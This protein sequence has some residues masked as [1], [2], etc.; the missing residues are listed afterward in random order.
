MPNILEVSQP[1]R[2]EAMHI[3]AA[4]MPELGLELRRNTLAVQDRLIEIL[5]ISVSRHTLTYIN[6]PECKKSDI[7]EEDY[8]AAIDLAKL[9][10]YSFIK[11]CVDTQHQQ[12]VNGSGREAEHTFDLGVYDSGSDNLPSED[13]QGAVQDTYFTAGVKHVAVPN[14]AWFLRAMRRY[15]GLGKYVAEH[16][17][18][19]NM[20]VPRLTYDLSQTMNG[21]G[22]SEATPELC[23][24]INSNPLTGDYSIEGK[25]AAAHDLAYLGLKRASQN[26]IGFQL[27]LSSLMGDIVQL[28]NG[29]HIYQRLP[30]KPLENETDKAFEIRVAQAEKIHKRVFGQAPWEETAV[31]PPEF[32]GPTFKCPVHQP[33]K[34]KPVGNL[35]GQLHASIKAAK[36]FGLFDTTL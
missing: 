32:W 16:F 3:A 23:E 1:D 13:F 7:P 27:S 15:G 21:A 33:T 22:L 10:R 26:V 2:N 19:T 30:T 11:F 29:R 4:S 20:Q 31:Y 36:T 17:A 35:Q 9:E 14:R 12:L 8:R 34:E 6:D 24:L 25:A 18:F 28:P 5:G